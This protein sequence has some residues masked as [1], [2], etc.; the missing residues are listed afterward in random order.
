MGIRHS[1][2]GVDAR[3]RSGD[4][5]PDPVSGLDVL[6]V[7]IYRPG[8][9][10][11]S[12]KACIRSDRFGLAWNT[13]APDRSTP[14]LSARVAAIL[15]GRFLV[16]VGCLRPWAEDRHDRPK[17]V[18][19]VGGQAE[20]SH[21]CGFPFDGPHRRRPGEV[22]GRSAG[23]IILPTRN[24]RD[25]FSGTTTRPPGAIVFTKFRSGPVFF[26]IV[27]GEVSG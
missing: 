7:L 23:P 27:F 17:G 25:A 19:Q 8:L 5:K 9:G 1:A 15:A 24:D 14:P 20:G 2:D 4:P 16:V 3:V 21:A 18:A 11:L 22:L 12:R 6:A 10:A 13:Q 26:A